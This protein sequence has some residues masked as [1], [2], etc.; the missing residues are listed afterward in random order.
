MLVLPLMLTFATT[1]WMFHE[2][3]FKLN[4]RKNFLAEASKDAISFLEKYLKF[5]SLKEIQK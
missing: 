1:N 4:I 2:G 5:T 3:R